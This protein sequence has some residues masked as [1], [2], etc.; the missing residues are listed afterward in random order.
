MPAVTHSKNHIRATC[1]R[2]G[3]YRISKAR[4]TVDMWAR[5]A[6]VLP[7]PQRHVQSNIFGVDDVVN[8]NEGGQARLDFTTA[9]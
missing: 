8:T 4:R 1:L 9:S 7:E 5:V 2:P 6:C 3:R